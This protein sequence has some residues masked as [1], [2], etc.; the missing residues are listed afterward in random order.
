MLKGADTSTM[1]TKKPMFDQDSDRKA[2]SF[3][4]VFP[5][6]MSHTELPTSRTHLSQ[7]M[8][9]DIN[10]L[11]G[12]CAVAL[13]E[14]SGMTYGCLVTPFIRDESKRCTPAV[15]CIDGNQHSTVFVMQRG[16]AQQRG[17][18]P[19]GAL[20]ALRGVHQPVQRAQLAA[21]GVL[22][23]RH[24]QHIHAVAGAPCRA[25][26][27]CRKV[28]T[29]SSSHFTVQARYRQADVKSL[30]ETNDVLVDFRLPIA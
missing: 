12:Y 24:A 30:P 21:L 11:L 16:E 3:P 25:V 13:M 26:A 28:F 10:C 9:H 29:Y 19:R 7:V 8:N 15:N 20:L 14:E 5:I 1:L 27:A 2:F 18:Q 17:C 23:L 4:T 22:A 6:E